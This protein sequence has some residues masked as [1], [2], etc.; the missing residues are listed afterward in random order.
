M[1]YSVEARVLVDDNGFP[2]T[3]FH[4]TKLKLR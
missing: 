2:H 1:G 3:W 4:I